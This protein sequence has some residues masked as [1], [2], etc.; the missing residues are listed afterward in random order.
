MTIATGRTEYRL[1]LLHADDYPNLPTLASGDAIGTVDGDTLTE[2][3]R[4]IGGFASTDVKPVNLTALNIDC[5]PGALKLCATDRYIIG[6]RRIDWDGEV[7]ANI[8]VP[9]ADLLATIKAL[10]GTP[11]ESIEILFNGSLLG[12]RTPSTTVI[13]R[14]LDDDFPD[15]DKVLA[16]DEFHSAVTVPTAD[17]TS[18]L[19]RA[20]SVADDEYAQ[21]DIAAEGDALSVTTTQSVVGHIDDSI[22]ASHYGGDR[23]VALSS[24][25]LFKA[26]SAIEDPQVTL[27][28]RE[29]GHLVSIYPGPIGGDLL[30][31]GTDTQAA[32]MGIAGKR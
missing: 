23:R 27:A 14:V 20:A 32:L 9:A 24:R 25:R 29:K 8:N 6:R 16:G 31:P 19:K 21:I 28:F 12:L 13:T 5:A 7:E 4:V 11:G 22:P 15:V 30:P 3:V 18:M 1:P 10:A 26:L 2:T 17:L